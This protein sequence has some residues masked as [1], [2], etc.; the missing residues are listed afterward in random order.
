MKN[1]EK[2]LIQREFAEK[3][4]ERDAPDCITLRSERAQR[5]LECLECMNPIRQRQ[6]DDCERS[7]LYPRAECP[8][9]AF[10]ATLHMAVLA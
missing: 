5:R 2:T 3:V 10:P 7:W 9:G 6:L 4:C 1:E 8:Q